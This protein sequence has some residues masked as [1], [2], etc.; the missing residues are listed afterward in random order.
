MTHTIY[1]T[2]LSAEANVE[3]LR[4]WFGNC[5]HVADVKLVVERQLAEAAPCAFVTMA[6]KQGADHAVSR[7]N[8]VMLDGRALALRL[9]EGGSD[10]RRDKAEEKSEAAARRKLSIVQQ[11]RE[12]GNMT[13]ELDC[14]GQPLILRMFFP[15]TDEPLA[16]RLDARSS[17]SV[18]AV[19][20]TA[21]AKSKELAL[22]D[23]AL[24]WDAAAVSG[25][26]PK[27]DWAAIKVALQSVRAV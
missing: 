4:A 20:L 18:Q 21:V 17:D 15:S 24:A 1:V 19:A 9:S 5:G 16:F 22:N 3:T 6:T 10:P 13:Y 11:Y 8:G 2:N 25:G 27:L 26:R 14:A 7:L 12:R 23:I